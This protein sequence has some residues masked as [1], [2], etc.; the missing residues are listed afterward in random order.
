MKYK[1]KIGTEVQGAD[2]IQG[3]LVCIMEG[4]IIKREKWSGENWYTLGHY[5][6]NGEYRKGTFLE[7]Q[8]EEIKNE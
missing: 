5:Q 7:S 8:L 1:Y 3:D 6:W 4:V 2:Y